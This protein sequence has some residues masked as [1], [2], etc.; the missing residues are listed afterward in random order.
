MSSKAIPRT[1]N[2]LRTGLTLLELIIVVAI[3]A[4][5]A[6]LVITKI[7]WSRRQTDMAAAADTCAELARNIQLYV[8]EQ[9]K[10]PEGFD[11]LIT[12]ASAAFYGSSSS[13][14]TTPG[15]IHSSPDL[16]NMTTLET[17]P[18][19]DARTNSLTRN[20][21][22]SVFDHDVATIPATNPASNS[23]TTYRAISRTGSNQ[24][25]CVTPGSA[26]W[27]LVYPVGL[28]Q[29]ET[30]ESHVSL[31]CVGVGPRNS[32]VGRTLVDAPMYS[33]SYNNNPALDYR[34]FVAVFAAY[35]DG[36]RAQFKT[37]VDSFGRTNNQALQQFIEA[38][39]Q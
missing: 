22:N 27:N 14:G 36:S 28:P 4:A 19:G 32:M 6:G 16:C 34:R 1:F 12:T 2:K 33:G 9:A 29:S 35:A 13:S 18:A 31:I 38:K 37:V 10:L 11:S 39:T 15:L 30:D 3:L 24:F 21:F 7:D 25:L 5:L 17:F 8:A 23:A 20:G 26:L